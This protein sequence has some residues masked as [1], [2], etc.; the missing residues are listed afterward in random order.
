[1]RVQSLDLVPERRQLTSDL[2][3]DVAVLLTLVGAR[4]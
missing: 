3:A 1:M 4:L 2:D